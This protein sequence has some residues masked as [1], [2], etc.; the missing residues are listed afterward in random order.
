LQ[1]RARQNTTCATQRANPIDENINEGQL[2]LIVGVEQWAQR[3]KVDVG[4]TAR[5]LVQIPQQK[6]VR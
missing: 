6:R 5:T 3:T 2:L 4:L 1:E